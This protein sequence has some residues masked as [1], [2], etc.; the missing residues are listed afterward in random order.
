MPEL[1]VDTAGYVRAA[2]A[3]IGLA[4]PAECRAG[5]ERYFELASAFAALVTTLPLAPHDEPAC[6]F[7]PV[8]PG[9]RVPR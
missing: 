7:T 2:A 9:A 6:V 8:E 1:P 5:V 3:A 4:I